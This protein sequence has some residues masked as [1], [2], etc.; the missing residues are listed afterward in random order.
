[1]SELD[2]LLGDFD[3]RKRNEATEQ[4][5]RAVEAGQLRDAT[6]AVLTSIIL[7]T[8][9]NLADALSAKGHRAE[10]RERLENSTYPSIEFVFEPRS[11]SNSH[12]ASGL[13]DSTLTFMHSDSG[14][15]QIREKVAG[16]NGYST[17]GDW[18]LDT[19][20]QAKVRTRIMKFIEAVLEVS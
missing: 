8:A 19:V 14:K 5:A 12:S 1:M 6:V 2:K 17:N 4:A 11:P 9:K 13:R 15:I 10:A 20:S 18:P 3:Q 7:P 16:S